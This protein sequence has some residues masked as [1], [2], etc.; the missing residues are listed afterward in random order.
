LLAIGC[1]ACPF[2]KVNGDPLMLID[3]FERKFI[4]FGIHLWPQDFHI[5]ALS[6]IT[7]SG[8]HGSFYRGIWPRMVRVGLSSDHFHGNGIPENRILDRRRCQQT[9]QTE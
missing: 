3:V 9:A 7:L 1:L 6:M 2:L 4:I 8:F 5:V